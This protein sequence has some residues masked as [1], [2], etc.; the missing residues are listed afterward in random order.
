MCALTLGARRRTSG[1]SSQPISFVYARHGVAMVS[2]SIAPSY[3]E[4]TVVV[5]ALASE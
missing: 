3:T 5:M 4:R 2:G 1:A